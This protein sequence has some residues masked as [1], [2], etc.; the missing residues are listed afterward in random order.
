MTRSAAT[1]RLASGSS[2]ELTRV[3]QRPNN[4]RAVLVIST[5]LVVQRSILEIRAVKSDHT[6]H[7]LLEQAF[8]Q[9]QRGDLATAE[10]TLGPIADHP[11]ALHLMGLVRVR[12]GRL[13]EAVDVLSQAVAARPQE[14]QAHFNH[15]KVLAALGRHREAAGAFSS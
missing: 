13:P 9:Y 14:A 4:E 1:L 8:A 15:G 6:V 7:A 2:S 11:S 5:A 10:A 12:Q 3:A